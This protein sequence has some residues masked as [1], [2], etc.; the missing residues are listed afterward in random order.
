MEADR[1][2]STKTSKIQQEYGN[3]LT[4][5]E[6]LKGTFSLHV[7]DYEKLFQA[8]QRPVA[9]ALQEPF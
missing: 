4:E 7:T 1:Q 2:M 5:I 3:V 6:W 8:P 9:H